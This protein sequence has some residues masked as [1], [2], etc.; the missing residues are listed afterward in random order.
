M[1]VIRTDAD[2]ANVDD[3]NLL[4]LLN[5]RIKEAQEYV[6]HFSELSFYVVIQ[7]GDPMSD[8]VAV[9]GFS[10]LENRFDGISFGT[11]SFTPSWD[12]IEEHERWFELVFVLGDDGSGVG[13]FISKAA[14]T[15]E[16]LLEMCRIFTT[17]GVK[18]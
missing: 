12:V 2:L 10:L 16:E 13:V 9:L 15:N 3:P 18:Q 14:G 6:D 1:Q 5:L 17:E 8:A 11:P 7:S 4:A